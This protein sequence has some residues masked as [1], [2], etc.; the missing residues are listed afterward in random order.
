EGRRNV[1]RLHRQQ[2]PLRLLTQA[3]FQDGD[4][5]QQLHRLMVSDV[6]EL[7][8]QHAG[9]N[10]VEHADHAFYNIVDIREVA[11]HVPVVVNVDGPVFKNGPGERKQRHVRTPPGTIH[12]EEAKSGGWQAV[13]VAVSVG[14]Q[15]VRALG[16][17]VETD[18]VVYGV[19]YRERL[20]PVGTVNGTR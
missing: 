17:R 3:S 12:G 9:G 18:R 14:H 4:E 8:R 11:L 7:V 19:L 20:L 2:T 13:K 10:R 1:P 16:G 6:V 5:V 15:L